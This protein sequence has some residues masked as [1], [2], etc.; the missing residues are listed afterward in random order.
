MYRRSV[1]LAVGGLVVAGLSTVPV[2]GPAVSAGGSGGHHVTARERAELS[3]GL[4][5]A[6]KTVRAKRAPSGPNPYLALVPDPSTV[7]YA[8]WD[9][10]LQR[11]GRN[12][13]R[14]RAVQA[15]P[16]RP[17]VVVDEDEPPGTLGANDTPGTATPVPGF[18]TSAN[19]RAR[20][21]GALAPSEPPIDD[22]AVRAE[23]NG[24]I[25]LAQRTGI[26]ARRAGVHVSARI[27]DGPHGRSGDGSGDF[28]VYRLTAH[29]GETITVD[30]DTPT[31]NLDTVVL[32][33][34]P[35]GKLVAAN[36]DSDGLDSRLAY[37]VPAS[38][39][40]YVFVTGFLVLPEDPFDSG[41]GSGAESQGPY[42]VTIT[43]A[44]VDVDFYAIRLRAGDVVGASVE[45]AATV[46]GLYD[47]TGRL[48][49]GSAQDATFI[50]P[51]ASPLPGGGNAVTEHV[52][53]RDGWHYVGVSSGAGRYDVTVEAYRPALETQNPVQTLF[54][55]FDGER[56]NTG[57]FGGSG[58]TTLSPLR[59]FLGRWG[60]TNADLDPLI[61]RIVAVV[62]ENVRRDLVASGLNDDFRV[63][64]L[65]SRDDPDPFGRPNVSR[66]VVGGTIAESG[67]DTIGI[68]Q[69]I[70]PG[71]FEQQE[72]ALVLLDLLS[73][74]AGP[75][76]SLNTYLRPASAKIRFIGQAVGNVTSHEAGHFFGN[77]HVAQFNP[78][79]NLM[80]QGGNFPVLYGVGPDHIG[81]TADDLDVDFG[82]DRFNP[83]EGFT[84][85]EDTLARV[86]F[87][88][89]S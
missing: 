27:G 30:T 11:Q 10:W 71:N 16:A 18:G 77:W 66:I 17:P 35:S 53:E 44:T 65:N 25:P 45:G 28:D 39:S 76:F 55:D 81:G 85:I 22:I 82:K 41:S 40:F 33:Y 9:R 31:G 43:A 32:L 29:A 67:V 50:Y 83:N 5:A 6:P 51:A 36:D 42:S 74:P 7:N 75:D 19:P 87:A 15:A 60:L 78:R 79:P 37:R 14:A 89:T 47:P 86:V 49:H 69:S 2:T 23:D 3:A 1:L 52:A 63:R 80:D 57:I 73:E 88:L 62:G 24:S 4:Q 46:L 61:D 56:L 13:E 26:S 20:L 70:D 68:A 59:A 64:I 54:L 21:L 72:T 34:D 8:R 84:G 12:R 38:G 48:V 58:V